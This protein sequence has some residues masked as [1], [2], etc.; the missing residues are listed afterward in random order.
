MTKST[1]EEMADA[2]WDIVKALLY[3]TPL[4][5]I[6]VAAPIAAY[7][8]F[9]LPV[10]ENAGSWF[11]R[12]GAITLVLALWV[13]FNLI[14]VNE[15]INISGVTI[16]DQTKLSKKYK[17]RYRI[18]QYLGIFLAI[19]GTVICSYGDLVSGLRVT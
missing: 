10:G 9:L 13:E 14:K 6:A 4:M 11:Q 5:M 1:Q 15:H 18:F 2:E 19:V 3:S 17:L 16:S 7:N 12:S 8:Q